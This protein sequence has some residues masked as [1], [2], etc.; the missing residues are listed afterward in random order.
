MNKQKSLADLNEKEVRECIDDYE[1]TCQTIIAMKNLFEFNFQAKCYQGKKMKTTDQN[2]IQ[3][4][5]EVTPDMVIEVSNGKKNYFAVN[6]IKVDLPKDKTLW[7][8]P[9]DQLKK[10][11]DELTGWTVNKNKKHDVMFTT[12]DPRTFAFNKHINELIAQGKLSFERNLSI[13]HSTRMEQN[14][15]FFLIKK[16]YGTI[17]DPD[18]DAMFSEG[19]PVNKLH[20]VN[21]MNQMKFYDSEPPVVY[22][23]MIIWDHVLKT[24]LDP[25]QSRELRANKKVTITKS[26]NEI[27][28]KLKRFTPDSNRNCIERVWVR[29]ALEGFKELGWAKLINEEQEIFEISIKIHRGKIRDKILKEIHEPENDL[30]QM[31]SPE[32]VKIQSLDD[33]LK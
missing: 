33:Y 15:T 13:L 10:Y 28:D 6:E 24:F 11:D 5:R 23:M 32:D 21:E 18:I 4:N 22:S 2:A 12:I 29:R 14:N 17:S 26:V 16:D 3:K 27:H 9:V 7:Q 20:M 31:K 30:T 25:K 19:R 8:E 1:F